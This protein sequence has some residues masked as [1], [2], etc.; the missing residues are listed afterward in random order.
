MRYNPDFSSLFSRKLSLP[1]IIYYYILHT[2]NITSLSS[3]NILSES[4]GYAELLIMV[5]ILVP[6]FIKIDFLI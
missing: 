5:T 2:Y 4:L 3:S 6:F 1:C